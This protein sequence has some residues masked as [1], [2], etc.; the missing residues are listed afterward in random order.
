MARTQGPLGAWMM[1]KLRI[2]LGQAPRVPWGL[3]A[4]FLLLPLALLVKVALKAA[5]V[6]IVLAVLTPF[7][8]AR[9]DK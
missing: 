8:F 7:V 6:L 9:F 4:L 5:L 3:A 2:D 1:R